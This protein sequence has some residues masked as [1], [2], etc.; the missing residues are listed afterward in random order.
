MSSGSQRSLAAYQTTAQAL[1]PKERVPAVALG[2]VVMHVGR[3][4]RAIAAGEI[5][6]AH[7]A[8]ITAQQI[9]GLLRGS[10]DHAAGGPLAASLDAV[11]TYLG[12]ELG[13]ANIEKSRE[14]LAGLLRV[15][16]PL[17]E[18]WEGAATAVLHGRDTAV[19]GGMAG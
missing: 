12:S 10:L 4:D 11:Y 15:L 13:R 14:R 5:M 18:A 8:L 16:A 6:A 17:V 3:A 1:I 9:V 19:R 2:G 7:D